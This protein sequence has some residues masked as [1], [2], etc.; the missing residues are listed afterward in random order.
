VTGRAR[1]LRRIVAT[2][3]VHSS[4]DN[5]TPMLAHLLAAREDTLITDCG[6]SFEGSGY[7][8]L[9]QGE[10]ERAVLLAL[11]D[12]VAPGNHGWPHYFERALHRITVCANAEDELGRPLFR[13]WRP[14]RIGERRVAVT[15]VIGVQA[16]HAIPAAQ[17]RGQRVTDPARALH[18][19]MLAH[20]HE[21][22]S[23]IVLSHSGFEEDL[24]LADACPFLDVVFAGHCHSDR[25]GPTRIGDTL[26]VKGP[27]LATGY[28]LAELAPTGWHA[29]T[30]RFPKAD[31]T[32]VSRQLPGIA[33]RITEVKGQLS[34]PLGTVRT[35]HRG[36][37]LDRQALLADLA[38]LLHRDTAADAVVLNVTALRPVRLGDVFSYGDLL[39]VEPFG[40]HLVHAHVPETY[41]GAPTALLDH[42]ASAAGPIVSAPDP[43]PPRVHCVLTTEYL[44]EN[45]LADS[46]PY[47]DLSLAQAVR[48]TLTEGASR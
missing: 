16:F 38:R 21:V 26:V 29:L 17:R 18:Q 6:D 3:D 32:A 36:T 2:T 7:Y 8:R 15:G 24:K 43:L 12:V 11:Y 35:A 31:A 14:F 9:A 45:Y 5:A 47:P 39:A 42:L 27:E 48:R 4:L 37:L 10:I 19:L 34:A 46:V 40:N 44:A 25:Y 28:A 30:A 22:D 33:R 23:W 20:H 41:R 13:P 1:R